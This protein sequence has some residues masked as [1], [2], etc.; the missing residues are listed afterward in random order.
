MAK[1]YDID[2]SALD[3]I[4]ARIQGEWDNKDLVAR[5]GPLST[6]TLADVLFIAKAAIREAKNN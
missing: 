4:V 1:T 6:D 5:G 3:A 2:T